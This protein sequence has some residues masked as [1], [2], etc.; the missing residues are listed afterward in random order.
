[1]GDTKKL[2][3]KY[4]TPMHP[5]NATR[6]RLEKDIM[7]KYGVGN[8]KEI[9]KMESVLKRF[10]DQA[11]RLLTR[12]DEQ[13]NRERKQLQE[14]MVRLGLVKSGS[15]VDDI[16]G[17]QLRD[18]MDRRLQTVVLRNRLARSI[19]H[20]RQLI[21]HEHV[22]V[23]G[24]KVT[25]PSYMVLASEE[26]SVSFA[27]DSPFTRPDHPEAF[28]EELAR[29]FAQKIRKEKG[30]EAEGIVVFDESELM[31]PED[32]KSESTAEASLQNLAV[33]DKTEDKPKKKPAKKEAPKKESKPKEKKT[34][35]KKPEEKKAPKEKPVKKK[36]EEKPKKE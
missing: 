3:K 8:K 31:D 32:A 23:G 12:T 10:K 1:M 16:L 15:S 13:A 17:L 30:E 5:W 22:L 27:S 28:S 14:R 29:M 11:K 25:S 35:E 20:A 4:T 19:K 7:R 34:D 33:E 6:I 24:K 18:V 9:W 21:T 2:R 26:G 36:A